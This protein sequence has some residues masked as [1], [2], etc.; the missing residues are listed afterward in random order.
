[1]RNFIV[2]AAVVGALSATGLG[3]AGAAAAVALGSSSMTDT[4]SIPRQEGFDS[5]P[6]HTIGSPLA[7]CTISDVHGLPVIDAAGNR[8]AAG[9]VL[10]D[11]DC[12][13]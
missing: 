7:S 1:M 6:D 3:L 5:A 11:F 12:L 13:P 8:N 10:V 2:T 9:I 4:V